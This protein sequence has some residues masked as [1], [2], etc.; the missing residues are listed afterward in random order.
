MCSTPYDC[1][2]PAY[3]GSTPRGDRVHGRVGSAFND[4]AALPA[5]LVDSE[6]VEGEIIEGEVII[7]EFTDGQIIDGQITGEQVIDGEIVD[8]EI[9]QGEIITGESEIIQ[10]EIMDS[11]MPID[12]EVIDLPNVGTESSE[13][14]STR[15]PIDGAA[16]APQIDLQDVIGHSVEGLVDANPSAPASLAVP[17]DVP[18]NPL[19]SNSPIPT[20]NSPLNSTPLNPLDRILDGLPPGA[21]QPTIPL[22]PAVISY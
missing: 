2:Y 17:K 22:S 14:S 15:L 7:D 12:S 10:G 13:P 21:N 16:A 20:M 4:A 1:H 9:L 19:N 18:L 11:Y 8:G 5:T 3:G 6:Y